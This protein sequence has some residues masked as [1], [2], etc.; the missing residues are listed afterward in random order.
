MLRKNFKITIATVVFNGASTLTETIES[1]INQTYSNI[2]YLIVDGSSKD[3][4]LAIAQHYASK[5]DFI[6]IKSEADKGIFDAMNKAQ[7]MATGD[8]LLFLGA[9]DTLY[10]KNTIENFVNLISDEN[11]VYYG[12]VLSKDTKERWFGRFSTEKI[13]LQNICHQAI[14]YSKNIYTNFTYNL[15]YKDFADW[16]YNLKVWSQ[17]NQF[18]RIEL[19]ITVYAQ[20]GNSYNNPDKFFLKDRRTLVEEYFGKKYLWLLKMQKMKQRFVGNAD[21]RKV[22][23]SL[24]PK[25]R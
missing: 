18:T 23:G 1:V 12:D 24:F 13:I 19:I 4:T 2:E 5:Y 14:F 9:D 21:L 10:N 25:L 17:Y 8:F 15:Y 22:K 3:S 11:N 20:T 16:D 6:K 7:Q